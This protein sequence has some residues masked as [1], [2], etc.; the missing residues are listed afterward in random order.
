MSSLPSYLY[1]LSNSNEELSKVKFD[2]FK[3]ILFFI[4]NIDTNIAKEEDC[5][6]TSIT[7][8]GFLNQMFYCNEQQKFG[9]FIKMNQENQR[10]LCSFM[11]K[12][13]RWSLE[14]LQSLAISCRRDFINFRPVVIFF[15]P[16][17]Y[18]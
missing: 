17:F 12:S 8:D 5:L 3:E 14:T 1:F 2:N 6:T 7:L 10:L 13:K 15:Y 9:C 18:S 16:A 4:M 11:F